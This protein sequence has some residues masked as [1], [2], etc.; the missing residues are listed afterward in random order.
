MTAEGLDEPKGVEQADGADLIGVFYVKVR[1]ERVLINTSYSHYVAVFRSAI[2][3]IEAAHWRDLLSARAKQVSVAAP[4][5]SWFAHLCAAPEAVNQVISALQNGDSLLSKFVGALH[6][7]GVIDAKLAGL[8]DLSPELLDQN[9]PKLVT[10]VSIE[11]VTEASLNRGPLATAENVVRLSNMALKLVPHASAVLHLGPLGAELVIKYRVPGQ[12]TEGELWLW[13]D[14][15][16]PLD[17]VAMM[18]REALGDDRFSEQ[19]NV[20]RA[21]RGVFPGRGLGIER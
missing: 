14:R 12:R 19:V 7:P 8:Q 9:F 13:P 17:R 4:L 5:A 3:L 21:V 18:M 20:W 1:R 15:S 6:E 2:T 16:T 11:Q 10:G